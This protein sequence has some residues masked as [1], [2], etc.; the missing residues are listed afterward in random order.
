MEHRDDRVEIARRP[1]PEEALEERRFRTVPLEANGRPAVAFYRN[2][3]DGVA[4]FFALHVIEG[5]GSLVRAIDHFMA[6]SA[7]RVFFAAGLSP[8]L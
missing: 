5:E 6:A 7:L 4:R 1:D 3:D 8:V 2:G